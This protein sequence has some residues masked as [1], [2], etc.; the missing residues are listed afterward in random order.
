M[1]DL[2]DVKKLNVDKQVR[3]Y[4]GGI[5]DANQIE[6][7]L[8]ERIQL[9]KDTW[10]WAVREKGTEAFLGIISLDLHHDG[11]NYEVSY[12]FLPK[13]WGAGYAMETVQVIITYALKVLKFPKLLAETQ[14]ANRASCMLLEKLGMNLEGI[15]YRFDAEQ[16]IY[17][18]QLE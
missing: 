16:A 9:E 6:R 13:W 12:Q 17:T 3:R 11:T 7:L 10:N 2:K 1:S 14:T 5:Y 15:I 18:I 8:N 4:L